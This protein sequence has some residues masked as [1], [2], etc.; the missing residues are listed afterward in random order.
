MLLE[1]SYKI[2]ATVLNKRLQLIEENLENHESQCGFRPGRGCT[3][4]TFTV[5]MAMKK[6]REHGLE[7][8]ILFLD[9]VK[10]FDRVPR[11]LLW[12]VLGKLGVPKKLIQLLKSLHVH[13]VVKFSVN[14]IFHEILNIIGVKQGDIL[15]PRLFNL[16][17]YAVMLTWH[18]LDSRQLCVFNTKRD[19]ILTGRSY[20]AR[21][22]QEFN[23]PDSQYAD[24]TALLFTS[25]E[26]LE[27]S[28][29]L[30][31]AHFAKFGLEIHVGRPGKDSKTEIL[32]VAAPAHTYK[33]PDNFDN[34]DLSIV[35]LSDNTYLPIVKEFCYLGTVLSRDCSDVKDV[36]K[37]IAKA[38]NAFGALRS[39][40]FSSRSVSLATKKHV[41]EG[42]ILPILLYGAEVWSLTEELFN[43]LRVFHSRC[44]RSMNC[45]NRSHV[46]K[47][48]IS[49]HDLLTRTG[50]Q[51]IDTYITRRQLQ[52]AGH[53]S[54]MEMHR[55]P[56]MMLSSW[57]RNK[58][59]RGC[60]QFTYGRGLTKAL[61]K[62]NIDPNNWHNVASDRLNWRKLLTNFA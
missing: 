59:P 31:I 39:V 10:A 6:R 52:W 53:V 33:D 47:H 34:R 32:F 15:G 38:S 23:L 8:W 48:S 27:E 55:L 62:A 2:V 3:D 12:K 56:R 24:D 4:A 17:I 28:T 43:K 57:V 35:K 26:S 46:W 45:I 44:I 7:S 30:M 42:V 1:T 37:R 41:Y 58:R 19:F 49:N 13:F 60:P 14:D 50:L 5:K 51:D 36:A 29:P 22:G 9:L 54:R 11:E 25:R 16:F 21:N 20:R 40:V 61:K 18:L